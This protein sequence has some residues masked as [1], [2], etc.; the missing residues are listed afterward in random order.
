MAGEVLTRRELNRTLL[1]RQLLLQRRAMTPGDALEHLVGMQAQNPL[2]PY[3]GLWSRLDGFDPSELSALVES[4]DAVRAWLMRGTIHLVTAR[5]CLALRPVMGSV[6]RKSFLGSR[7]ARDAADV[8]WD[9]LMAAT[10]ELLADG[11]MTR[12]EIG[13]ALA[14]RWPGVRVE[15]LG[16]AAS[17]LVPMLQV[18]PRGM[19]DVTHRATQAHVER[20]LGR[21]LTRNDD[22]DEAIVRYLRAFGP[23]A[24]KDVRAW[25]YRT[26]LREAIERLRP[27]LVTYRDENGT[28]LLDVPG[29]KLYQ[30][31]LPVPPR[32]LPE[33]DNALLSHADRS[34]VIARSD[35]KRVW[36]RG[37]VLVDGFAAGT[38]RFERD[39]RSV[40]LA[41]AP[42]ERWRKRD[43]DE[44]AA[45]AE[46]LLAFAEPSAESTAVRFDSPGSGQ[47]SRA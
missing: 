13:R 22:P 17:H 35:A 47:A 10:E 29:G 23:A 7:F 26:G 43:R 31:D 39:G 45:E 44:V 4:G 30:A 34:R 8:D 33:F 40:T 3:F 32:F 36:W 9:Q 25:S 42:W 2:D 15:T 16:L 6:M 18:P 41:I 1:G 37:S 38:W 11:P 27:G 5:D 28:E 21:R 46:R 20:F 19:W 14:E 24:P 12:A